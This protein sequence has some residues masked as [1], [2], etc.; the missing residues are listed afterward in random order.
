MSIDPLISTIDEAVANTSLPMPPGR[1]PLWGPGD[2]PGE[3]TDVCG[4]KKP[5]GSE[6][7][8]EIRMHGAFTIPHDMLGIKETDQSCHHEVL[9]PPPP[10]QCAAGRSRISG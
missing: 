9:G 1:T 3:W 10:R 2:V 4:F 7:E 6:N 8:W 5:L